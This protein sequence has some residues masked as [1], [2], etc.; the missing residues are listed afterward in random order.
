MATLRAFENAA[1]YRFTVPP[2]R[3]DFRLVIPLNSL[4][5]DDARIEDERSASRQW[6]NPSLSALSMRTEMKFDDSSLHLEI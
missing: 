4:S 5:R 3:C 6:P 2:L 1:M